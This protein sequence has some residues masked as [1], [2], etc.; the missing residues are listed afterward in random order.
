MEEKIKYKKITQKPYCC[1]GA[2]LEMILNR[3]KITNK[4]QEDIAYE[5]GLVVPEKDENLFK[6]ARIEEK[7]IAGYGTQIQKEEYSINNYFRKHNIQLI[8]EYY[9]ITDTEKAKKFFLK[10]DD[11]DILICCHCGTLYDAPHADWG[12][13]LLFDHLEDDIVVVLDPSPKR[14]YEKIKIET[15]IK[16]IEIHGIDKGAGFWLIKKHN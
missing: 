13:M 7:P 1:C 9:Y 5:L 8:Q 4:G 2:C 3:H 11:N 16:S 15:L 10:N 12:H 6:K 14:N